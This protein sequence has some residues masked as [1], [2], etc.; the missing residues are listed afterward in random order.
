LETNLLNTTL[1]TKSPSW[2]GL[3]LNPD[4]LRPANNRLSCSTDL[5]ER[6]STGDLDVSGRVTLKLIFRSIWCESVEWINP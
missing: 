3:G 4:L 2:T 6:N 1:L 5:S